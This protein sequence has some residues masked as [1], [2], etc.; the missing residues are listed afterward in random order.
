MKM[1]NF[2]RTY[3]MRRRTL[4]RW[5]P[6][7]VTDPTPLQYGFEVGLWTFS[8]LC[9]FISRQPGYQNPGTLS[10]PYSIGSNMRSLQG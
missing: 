3:G 6:H 9:K 2:A 5:L 8:I 10:W 1:S 4:F 7:A